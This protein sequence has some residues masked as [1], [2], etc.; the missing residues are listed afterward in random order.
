M[1][2]CALS[3]LAS[4]LAFSSSVLAQDPTTAGGIVGP[5]PPT[6]VPCFKLQDT[7]QCVMAANQPTLINPYSPESF[8]FI[9]LNGTWVDQGGNRPTLY[10]FSDP[11]FSNGYAVSIFNLANRPDAHGYVVDGLTIKVLFIDDRELTGTI[12]AR[13]T[14]ISWSNNTVWRKQ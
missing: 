1:K 13:G 14:Q 4:L 8:Y 10:L 11:N 12:E 7:N 9:D 6:G 5:L 2:N 3:A